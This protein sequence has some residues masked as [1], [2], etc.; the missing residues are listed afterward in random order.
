MSTVR[1]LVF[2]G[3]VGAGRQGR[4]HVDDERAAGDRTVFMAKWPEEPAGSSQSA[5]SSDETG[6]DR[7]A[8]GRR[9][10]EAAQWCHEALY[11]A[12]VL[13]GA[14]RWVASCYFVTP[15][16]LRAKV[17]NDHGTMS[18]LE[19]GVVMS[20]RSATR[21]LDWR[22]GCGSSARPVR[23]EGQVLSLLLPLSRSKTANAQARTTSLRASMR[24]R[25][26][27]RQR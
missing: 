2:V 24:A 26:V 7:G 10:R 3:M 11:P 14:T 19:H 5:H 16:L 18:I 13:T 22:A 12:R 15:R 27:H 25:R 1:T 8:K 23:R 17:G 21:S 6:N 20:A 4:A 9:E